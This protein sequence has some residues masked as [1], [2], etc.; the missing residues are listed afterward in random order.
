MHQQNNFILNEVITYFYNLVIF[1]D[2]FYNIVGA[3]AAAGTAGASATATAATN[4]T[5]E[6]T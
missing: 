1:Y 6:S 5:Y 2:I 4:N 3:S